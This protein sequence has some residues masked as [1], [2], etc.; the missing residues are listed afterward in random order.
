MRRRHQAAVR[1]TVL[2]GMGGPMAIISH[3]LVL[4]RLL[5]LL[6]LELVRPLLLEL[7]RQRLLPQLALQL[8]HPVHTTVGEQGGATLISISTGRFIFPSPGNENEI[9]PPG[10]F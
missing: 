10:T 6:R 5:I 4:G 2:D 3:Q 9:Q 1:V 8:R 7:P